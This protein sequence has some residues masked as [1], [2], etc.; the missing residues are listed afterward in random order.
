MSK[1]KVMIR[2]LKNLGNVVAAILLLVGGIFGWIYS[3]AS[4]LAS[5]EDQ[6]QVL[7]SSLLASLAGA[8]ALVYAG[9][10][11]PGAAQDLWLILAPGFSATIWLFLGP[12]WGKKVNGGVGLG[13]AVG[14]LSYMMAA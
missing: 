5:K 7:K 11:Y 8:V 13:I 14:V 9:V 10:T 3:I 6:P 12:N 2:T 1:K 4:L